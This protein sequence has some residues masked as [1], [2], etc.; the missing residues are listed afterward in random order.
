MTS[1][2]TEQLTTTTE[3]KS[4]S[5]D[6]FSDE[7]TEPVLSQSSSNDNAVIVIIVSTVVSDVVAVW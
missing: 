3:G 4:A 2:D 5:R 7:I 1:T 6:V